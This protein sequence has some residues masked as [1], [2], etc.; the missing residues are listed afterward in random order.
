MHQFF[1]DEEKVKGHMDPKID[2]YFTPGSLHCYLLSDFEDKKDDATELLQNFHEFFLAGWT[3]DSDEFLRQLEANRSFVP[4]GEE[5]G[6]FQ[7]SNSD[8][9][10]TFQLKKTKKI[11]EIKDSLSPEW[12]KYNR[13][14]QVFIKFY[15]E[16]G[17][18]IDDE[19]GDWKIE[20]LFEYNKTKQ[21]YYFV[22]L[23][24]YYLF[25]QCTDKYRL[26]ISQQLI[27]PCYQ[28]KG[29]GGILLEKIYDKYINEKDCYEF[30]VEASSPNFQFMR[31][32]IDVKRI[33]GIGHFQF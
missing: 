31:D 21:E 7:L 5:T 22:G 18:Y 19:D 17:S 20:L 33:L 30:T 1:E 23:M 10:V 8:Y 6:E 11:F 3:E 25:Y 32:F 4:P 26:R 29:L 28:R 15:I 12:I 2:L 13:R 27:L 14:L 9:K 16:T 24:T